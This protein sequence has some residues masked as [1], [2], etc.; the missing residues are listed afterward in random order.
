M[1]AIHLVRSEIRSC[2]W[3]EQVDKNGGSIFLCRPLSKG[4]QNMAALDEEGR[5]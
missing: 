3:L 4:S 1:T 2:S 5:E